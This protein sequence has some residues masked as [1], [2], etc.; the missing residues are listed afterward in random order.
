MTR[1]TYN[2]SFDDLEE[3]RKPLKIFGANIRRARDSR[4]SYGGLRRR[5]RNG[6]EQIRFTGACA[7]TRI[8]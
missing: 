5:S 4:K 7:W 1:A 6:A 8:A 3:L 2:S